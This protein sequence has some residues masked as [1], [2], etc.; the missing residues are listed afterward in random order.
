MVSKVLVCERLAPEGLARLE[1][2]KD[3]QVDLRTDLTP[4]QLLETVGGY[5]AIIVRSATRVTAD[6]LEAAEKLRVIGRAGVGVDNIDIAAATK[7]G[8]MVLNAPEGNIV[9]TAE[10]TW[11]MLLAV[12]RLLPQ[13]YCG[14]VR[15][16]KWER[17]AFT[18]VQ[19][20][21]KTLGVVG[22]GRVGSEVA[23]RAAAFEMKVLAYDPFLSEERVRRVGAEPVSLEELY[24]R[25]DFISLH[26]TLTRATEKMVNAEAFAAMKDGVRIVNCA[27]GGLID[28][29]ALFEAIRSGKVAGAALDV[30][31]EEPA[32]NNRLLDLPQVIATPHLAASTYE[33]QANVAQDVCEAVVKALRGEPVRNAVNA[34]ALRGDVDGLRPYL[35]LAERLGRLFTGLFRGGHARLEAV[36]RGKAAELDLRA[37]TTALL[38]GLLEPILHGEVNYVN[39]PVLAEER[40]I[41]LAETRDPKMA[42]YS[43]RIVLRGF[44][45]HGESAVA[46]SVNESGEPTLV[47]IDGYRLNVS[48]RGRL[49]VA[50]NVDRP[51]I[52]GHVGT[53]LGEEQINIAFMQVGRSSVGGDAVMVVGVDNPIADA[54]LARLS[55]IEDLKDVKL[56]EW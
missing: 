10:H 48:S 8:V 5:D 12:A 37:L 35:D 3:L 43:N 17:H 49:L 32:V 34:P 27:R 28:E 31:A 39:A 30:F 45:D 38:K 6:V 41:R 47:A 23:K 20:A 25:A 15:G 16:R 18:G 29:E 46:G 2:E 53:V 42:G 22:L 44:S 4:A 33:A 50:R 13:A 19:L 54:T 9:S 14:L 1:G 52:I 7:R 36:Y 56:V 40:Q 11:A 26:T 21:G 55:Q 24:S 51:G